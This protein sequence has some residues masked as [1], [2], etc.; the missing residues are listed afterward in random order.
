MVKK[1]TRLIEE[2]E[3]NTKTGDIW[4]INDVGKTWN[5]KTRA[6]VLADGYVFLD[7]GTAV[8]ANN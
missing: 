2:R 6:A 7:D 5:A 8:K 1:Y 4:S 3:L